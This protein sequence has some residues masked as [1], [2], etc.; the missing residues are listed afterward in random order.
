VSGR[1][2]RD[3]VVAAI[4][5]G[6]VGAGLV[7][8]SGAGIWRQRLIGAATWAILVL[9]LRGEDR[10]VRLQVLAVVGVATMVEFTA[11]PLLG[12]YTYRLHNVPAYVPPG[13]GIVYLFALSL[14]RSALFGSARRVVVPAVLA[15]AAAWAIWG[16]AL[17]P[18]RDVL[19]AIACLA[20][21]RFTLAG[22]AP[23]VFAAAFLVTSFLEV[24]G[25]HAGDWA[26][27]VH[28]P[29]GLVPI[30][31]PPSVIAGGYCILD[32]CGVFLGA[33]ALTLLERRHGQAVRPQAAV[34]VLGRLLRPRVHGG[35][36]AEVDAVGELEP[37]VVADAR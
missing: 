4:A 36:P 37:V 21:V 25:T 28:D 30:G 2:P 34:E 10:R 27:A 9:L 6:W 22:R 31:N 5:G 29:T 26:W 17:S 32:A 18:R 20:L 24:V 12:L 14:G 8:D 19:G 3:L 33:S 16:L 1:P 13:H 15:T 35:A 11:S 23:L 7:L